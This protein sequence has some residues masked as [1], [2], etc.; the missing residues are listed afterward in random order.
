MKSDI[1]YLQHI[2]EAISRIVTYVGDTERIE[3]DADQMLQDAII[4]QLQVIGEATR[5]LS[6]EFKQNHT[7]L[8]WFHII[9]M[10]NRI[11]HEYF[12]VDLEIVWEVV[13]N[14]LGMIAEQI[15]KILADLQQAGK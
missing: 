5:S 9:G 10:R 13:Q 15:T 3:F 2:L 7:E 1:V 8:P 12:R 11:I 14:D 4:R 6:P